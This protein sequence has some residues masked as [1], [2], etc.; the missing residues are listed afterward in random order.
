MYY[1]TILL[2]LYVILLVGWFLLYRLRGDTIWWLALVSSFAP[3]LFV[4]LLPSLLIVLIQPSFARWI[5]ILIPAFIFLHLYGTLFW[6]KRL[7]PSLRTKGGQA[8]TNSAISH[9][10]ASFT[11]M[12]FNI[13]CFSSSDQTAQALLQNG[14]PDVVAIQELTPTMVTKIVDTCNDQYPYRALP[15]DVDGHF[16][17]IFSRY[18]L[19][20]IDVGHL[21]TRDFRLS[22]VRVT[23]PD[24]DFLLYN[25]HPRAT[26]I[27][28][29]KERGQPI[30]QATAQSFQMRAL[31]V[32]RLLND[33]AKRD[34]ATVV[35]GDFNSSAQSDV[36]RLMS[37][38]LTDAHRAAGWGFGHTFPAHRQDVGGLPVPP[39]QLRLDM[40]F[41]SPELYARECRVGTF[42]GESD[43]APVIATLS[44]RGAGQHAV[45]DEQAT[46]ALLQE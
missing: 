4:P 23:T 19:T 44:W 20:E 40:I 10:S 21:A 26:N 13:W 9:R 30:P 46:I 22:T 5:A 18:P 31:F 3:L 1:L 45:R 14:A 34:E 11:L 36:Y 32:E 15:I 38:Q 37:A 25:I 33:I 16:P 35:V 29:Y 6:P 17:G 27:A 28:Q 7:S 12:T 42:H 2:W 8:A 43:H 41:Y 24:G 39:W